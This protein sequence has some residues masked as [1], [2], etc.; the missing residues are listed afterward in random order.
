M[1]ALTMNLRRRWPLLIGLVLG[2]AGGWLYWRLIGCTSGS[3][4]I[5]TNP[6]IAT[7]YGALLGVL[8]LSLLLPVR[9][10]SAGSDGANSGDSPAN[11]AH[12]PN[13]TTKER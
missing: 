6:W 1:S 2:A 9:R 11:P 3:C 10:A 8:L 13:A 7:G 5:W 4:P 12:A